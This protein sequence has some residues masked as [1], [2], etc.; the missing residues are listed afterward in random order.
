MADVAGR[1][2]GDRSENRYAHPAHPSPEQRERTNGGTAA[3]NLGV[4]PV[5]YDT[6]ME[7]LVGNGSE[8]FHRGVAHDVGANDVGAQDAEEP[9]KQGA[10]KQDAAGDEGD[11]PRPQSEGADLAETGSNGLDPV[12][13]AAA[14]AGFVV[15]GGGTLL[16]VRGRRRAAA[17]PRS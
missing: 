4:T 1:A 6:V 9:E 14:A 8:S 12:V 16:W 7:G 3:Y 17:G 15:V 11:G 2:G 13:T 5:S 10:K